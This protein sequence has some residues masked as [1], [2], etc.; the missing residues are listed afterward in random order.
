LVLGRRRSRDEL[1]RQPVFSKADRRVDSNHGSITSNAWPPLY[2]ARIAPEECPINVRGWLR[3][4][5][6]PRPAGVRA[7]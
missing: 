7:Q 6:D 4:I 1:L 2:V 3:A 5:P